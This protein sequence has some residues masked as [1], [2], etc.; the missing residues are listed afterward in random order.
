MKPTLRRLFALGLLG[1]AAAAAGVGTQTGDGQRAPAA[2]AAAHPANP[3]W[4]QLTADQR[5]ALAP[6]AGDWDKYDA[7]RKKKWLDIAVRYKDLSPE[8]QQK[9]HERMPDLAKLTPEQRRTARENFKKAYA[10][11]PDQRRE[12]TQKFQDLPEEKKRELAEQSKKK[13]PA[14]RRP[15]AA[16][17]PVAT[18][19]APAATGSIGSLAH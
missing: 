5:E 4:A 8:G 18:T 13:T 9:M 11:P 2:H 10:L 1:F 19:A 3:S 17:P 14:P 15:G 12:L 16:H 6:L 7:P